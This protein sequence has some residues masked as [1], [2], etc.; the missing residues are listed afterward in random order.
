MQVPV[1]GQG[2]AAVEPGGPPQVGELAAG[3]LHEDLHRRHVPGVDHRLGG[4]VDDP[5][6]DQAVLPEVAE[7]AVLPAGV[8][9]PQVGL[10]RKSVV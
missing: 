5:F 2:V 4:Q 9:Q 8:D 7:G 10:D 6:R 3:L 1:A